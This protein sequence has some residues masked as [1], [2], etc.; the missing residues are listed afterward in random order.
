MSKPSQTTEGYIRANTNENLHYIRHNGVMKKRR[1][2]SVFKNKI[3]PKMVNGVTV[4]GGLP[5]ARTE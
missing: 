1:R 3:K 2:R 5:G 4:L